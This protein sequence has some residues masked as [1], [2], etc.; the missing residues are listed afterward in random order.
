MFVFIRRLVND[1]IGDKFYKNKE[2]M[3]SLGLYVI[4]FI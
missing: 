2:S 4:V 3:F 1:D